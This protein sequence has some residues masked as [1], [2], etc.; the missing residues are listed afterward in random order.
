MK[1]NMKNPVDQLMEWREFVPEGDVLA[2]LN[3]VAL[4]FQNGDVSDIKKNQKYI[5]HLF[6]FLKACKSFAEEVEPLLYSVLKDCSADVAETFQFAPGAKNIKCNDVNEF[7]KMCAQHNVS[8]QDA[9]RF[10][11]SGITLKKAMELFNQPREVLVKNYSFETKQNRD[12][13]TVK[14]LK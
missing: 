5:A 7:F 8:I 13:I 11:F 6:A 14:P 9:C 2:G 4:F 10:M 1:S 12:R 3:S